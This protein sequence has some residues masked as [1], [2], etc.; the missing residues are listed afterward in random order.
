M[1]SNVAK[2]IG[3]EIGRTTMSKLAKLI[4][5]T[6]IA[7]ACMSLLSPLSVA[8]DQVIPQLSGVWSNASRTSLTRPRGLETLVVTGDEAE[9]I[10]AGMSI[11]GISAEMLKQARLSIQKLAHHPLAVKISDCVVITYFGPTQ[12]PLWHW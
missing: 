2:T 5:C 6:M 11:A 4:L 1:N 9:K 3:E 12:A 10:V 7:G 8:Q